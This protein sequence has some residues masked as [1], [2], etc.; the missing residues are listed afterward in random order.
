MDLRVQVQRFELILLPLCAKMGY[1]SCKA[2][3]D[4]CLK[5]MTRPEDIVRYYAYILCYVDDIPCIHHDSALGLL[6][7]LKETCKVK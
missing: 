5:D 4:L 3:P 6:A 2:N 1:A 7:N